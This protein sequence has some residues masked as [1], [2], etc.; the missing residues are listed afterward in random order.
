M[1]AAAVERESSTP[2]GA[3]ITPIVAVA[4]PRRRSRRALLAAAVGGAGAALAGLAARVGPARAAAGDALIVGQANHAG[5]SQT[6]LTTTALGA[7]FTLKTDNGS[8]GATGIFGWAANTGPNATRGVYGRSDAPAGDGVQGVHNGAAGTGAAVRAVGN[9]NDGVWSSTSTGARAVYAEQGSSATSA[10]AV[11]GVVAP[12]SAGSFSTAVRAQHNGTGGN[13]I[14]VWASHAGAGWA[15]LGTAVNGTGVYAIR[16]SATGVGTAIRGEA[17]SP[18]A[19]GGYFI[20]T[21]TDG[22]GLWA[23]GK[24]TG[25]SKAVLQV[26]NTNVGNTTGAMSAYVVNSSEAATA[27]IRNNGSGRV[28]FLQNGGTD[29]DGTEGGDFIAAVNNPE[30]DVQFRVLTSGEVRSDV[31]FNTPAADFAEMLDAEA[32]LEPGDVLVIGA[33]GRLARSQRPHQ[34]TLAGV[35][36]TEPGFVGGKPVSGAPNGHVPL[37]VVGIVPVKASAENGPIAPGDLLTSSATP[38]HAMRANGEARLGCV[39]GKALQPLTAGTGKVKM[40]VILH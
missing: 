2:P 11:H 21:S 29:E 16:S 4:W 33:D 38:G 24:G 25:R 13:G 10:F 8:T 23:T 30:S 40:L 39:I 3:S 35:Y 14:G 32:G 1:C 18:D 9:A 20:N 26:H 15:V 17:A 28:L 31:G 7:S 27:H 19:Q 22:V 36:S 5:S 37:A 6:T 12:T 34:E